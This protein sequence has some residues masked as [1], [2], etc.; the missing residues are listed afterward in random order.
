MNC[1]NI[2]SNILLIH[3]NIDNLWWLQ[4]KFANSK[5]VK[6]RSLET[7]LSGPQQI[8]NILINKIP[9]FSAAQCAP[10]R[11]LMWRAVS[12]VMGTSVL[13]CKFVWGPLTLSVHFTDERC[14]ITQN[15]L[16]HC[17]RHVVSFILPP[18]SLQFLY[19]LYDF[20]LLPCCYEQSLSSV[21]FSSSDDSIKHGAFK[22]AGKGQ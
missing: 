13:D 4:S 16:K 17:I 3:P 7:A 8:I 22:F 19:I 20:F 11:R 14:P 2:S 9:I 10:K 21:F 5:P 12:L 15:G 1:K 6:Y 18:L